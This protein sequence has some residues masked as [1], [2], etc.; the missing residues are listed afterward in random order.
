MKI[1]KYSELE[2]FPYIVLW[3]HK[4]ELGLPDPQ[5][6][7]EC[8]MVVETDEGKRICSG[9]L[10]RTDAKFSII[11]AVMS[12]P[13]SDPLVRNQA[14][15]VLFDGLIELSRQCGFKMI[16]VSTNNQRLCARYEKHGFVAREKGLTIFLR[17]EA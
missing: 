12:D 15:D 4:R 6:Y 10:F 13:E 17:E 5:Y 1:K 14:L 16:S 9:F 11:G 3:A 8:G 2:D 7:P